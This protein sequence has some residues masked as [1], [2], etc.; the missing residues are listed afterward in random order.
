MYHVCCAVCGRFLLLTTDV[1]AA[2]G[3]RHCDEHAA[4]D[5]GET[6]VSSAAGSLFPAAVD[7]LGD[8]LAGLLAGA[9]Y[10][11]TEAIRA[12][13]D[14]ELRAVAGIGPARLRKI[15]EVLG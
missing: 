2:S 5:A 13:S 4:G 9:G 11:S 15:R 8:E 10:D 3:A 12:A 1:G 6:A 7:A 14:A